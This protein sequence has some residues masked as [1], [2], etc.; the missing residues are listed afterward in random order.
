MMKL[1]AL[2]RHRHRVDDLTEGGRAGLYVDHCERIRLRKVRA[3]QQSIC[4]IFRRSFHG[5]LWRCMEGWVRPNWHWNSPVLVDFRATLR[6][7]HLTAGSWV[8]AHVGCIPDYGAAACVPYQSCRGRT[9][10][11]K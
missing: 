3:E 1:I 2:V 4:E 9:S 11:A 10:S 7:H 8:R 5:K 6:T